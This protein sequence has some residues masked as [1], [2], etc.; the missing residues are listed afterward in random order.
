MSLVPVYNW[1]PAANL[2]AVVSTACATIAARGIPDERD[3]SNEQLFRICARIA[4]GARADRRR[5][6]YR[7]RD[8][9]YSLSDRCVVSSVEYYLEK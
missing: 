4:A 9:S 2:I 7:S 8:Q 3:C 1:L 6:G 5:L